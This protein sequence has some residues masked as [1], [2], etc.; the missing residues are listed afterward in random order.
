MT[1]ILT[2]EELT[3]VTGYRTPKRQLEELHRHGFYRAKDGR[4]QHPGAD[5]GLHS[6]QES[7]QVNGDPLGG[8]KRH[9]EK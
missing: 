7:H 1:I 6:Q 3:G 2:T 5:C 8:L 9:T 4:P